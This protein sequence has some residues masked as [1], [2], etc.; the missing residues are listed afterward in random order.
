MRKAGFNVVNVA[1]VTKQIS[2]PSTLDYVRFQLTATLMATLLKDQD[3]LS[4]ERMIMSI[5]DDAASHLDP[6]MLAGDRMTF[7]QESFVLT[8]I[9][10]IAEH[11]E[12]T[13]P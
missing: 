7:P 2:F 12:R 9:P 4:R 10:L 5:A 13:A 6:T 1:T 8:A 11:Q 3:G